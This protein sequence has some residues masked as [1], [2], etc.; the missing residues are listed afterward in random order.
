[1]EKDK[2]TSEVEKRK[3]SMAHVCNSIAWR[4]RQEGLE[5]KASLH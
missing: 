3:G 5:F 1:M 2:G 4:L